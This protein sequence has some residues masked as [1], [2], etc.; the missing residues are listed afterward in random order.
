M[1]II[2]VVRTKFYLIG[3]F[4]Y[5]Y[6][7]KIIIIWKSCN[8]NDVHKKKYDNNMNSIRVIIKNVFGFLKTDEK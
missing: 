4:A 5:P 6:I 8:P 7:L 2:Q 1:I 3:N